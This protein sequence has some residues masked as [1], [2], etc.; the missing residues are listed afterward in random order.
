MD[1]L[2]NF[3]RCESR[4]PGSFR[5]WLATIVENRIRQN[6][7]SA[8]AA[9]RDA[10]RVTP[11]VEASRSDLGL[12]ALVPPAEQTSPSGAAARE[13]E[14]ARLER[15]LEELAPD[16]RDVLRLVKLR[17]LSIAEVAR[18]MQRSENAVKKLLARALGELR[19]RLESKRLRGLDDDRR[20]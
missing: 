1:A 19:A 6:L 9:R 16:Q 5:R 13:E 15:V 8:F 2:A 18:T 11:L 7:R 3:D 14:R 4:G 20:A 10:G 12:P 17:E